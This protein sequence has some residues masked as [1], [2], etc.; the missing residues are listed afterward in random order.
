[1][2]IL[3]TGASG[4]VGRN[5]KE[6]LEHNNEYE[7]FAP[8]STELDCIDE[9]A[10]EEYL[11]KNRFDYVLHFAVYSNGIDKTK[12]GSK[13]LEYNLRMFMNFA[14]NYMY[15]GKMYYSG[16]GAEYDKRYDICDV[17]EEEL[18]KT[19]PIDQYGLMKYTIQQ[20]IEKSDNIVNMRLFGVFGKYE[21]YPLKYISL[22]CC[23]AIKGIP[24]SM[25]Q[26]VYFDYLWIDDF[27][28]MLEWFL[29]NEPRYKSYN[30]VSGKKISLFEICTI[31]NR[32]SNK[33]LPIYICKEGLA[34]EYTASN[35]RFLEECPNFKYTS[36]EIAIEELYKWY[37]TQCDIDLYKL[38][39]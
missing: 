14:K 21:Y 31:I 39:Y 34:N 20:Y 28:R 17:R 19:I 33:D 2:K 15:Y 27:C 38:L 1:M 22:G 3:I 7:I 35:K 36:M 5:V 12:D 13:M 18:G 8:S 30:M 16:S 32:I 24:L 6:H 11:K 10:V 23:K 26:N 25:R 29:H 9:N 4:F 37:E